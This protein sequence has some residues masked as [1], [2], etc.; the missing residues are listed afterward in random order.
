[1]LV[2]RGLV[3]TLAQA[4]ALLLAGRVRVS[5]VAADKAGQAVAGDC[6]LRV[7]APRRRFVSRGGE[8]L[9]A[10]L[11]HF[12]IAVEGR[13]CV[14]VGASTG[15]FTD[16]LLRRGA[17]RVYAVDTGRGRIDAG[18]RADPRVVM[19]ERTNARYLS[20]ED[21]P[22]VP[23]LAVL[24]VSFISLSKILP[25]LSELLATGAEVLALVKPQF[26][27]PRGAVPHG[28]IVRDPAVR[29]AA[30]AG[31]ARAGE[32]CGL[33]VAG[34]PFVSPTPGAGGNV[35]VFLRFRKG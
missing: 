15:G 21:L 7:E 5:G 32:S 24:D 11:S 12:A 14:D 16:C 10:A 1:L 30:V 2:A 31:V 26:E 8:K 9:D 28:G 35:E 20:R 17:A 29:E 34:D 3:E 19:R 22:E 33:A 4:R 18:L 27:A 25:P 13:I 6:D 23:A